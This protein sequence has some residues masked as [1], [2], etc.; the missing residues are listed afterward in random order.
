MKWQIPAKT[1]LLGEYAALT[2]GS[3]ILITTTPYF[4]L[5]LTQ[6]VGLNG[7]H[8]ESP[9]GRFWLSQAHEEYGLSWYDP[10]HSGGL[11]ASSAQFIGAYLASAHLKSTTTSIPEIIKA[12]QQITEITTGQK[13]SGYDLIAQYHSGCVYINQSTKQIQST[14]WP[15]QNLS[16]ILLHTGMKLKTHEHLTTLNQI[17]KTK[18]LSAIVDKAFAAFKAA[19]ERQLIDCVNEYHQQLQQQNLVATHSLHMIAA[20]KHHSEILAVKGCGAL[21]ADLLLLM[22]TKTQANVLQKKLIEEGRHLI[23][24]EANLS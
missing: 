22:T 18:H 14:P 10:Y 3:A 2:Q 4:E 8:S 1:F 6:H 13:P 5:S 12:Y 17:P 20:L 9:G 7:I 21:G 15:F 16:F 11:G 23:A 24:T 19:D